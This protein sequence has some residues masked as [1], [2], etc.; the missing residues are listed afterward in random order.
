[1]SWAYGAVGLKA[2]HPMRQ[3]FLGKTGT[4]IC[5]EDNSTSLRK[6][7][8]PLYKSHR[9]ER[10]LRRPRPSH[11][12]VRVFQ[13]I[14]RE[15]ASLNLVEFPGLEA[16]DLIALLAPK[17]QLPIIA[18]DKDLLQIPGVQINKLDGMPLEIAN[19]A[20]RLPKYVQP[21]VKTPEDI[22]LT[23][24]LMG[25]KSD[26]IPRLVRPRELAVMVHLLGTKNRWEI[27]YDMFKGDL[28]RNLYLAVLPAPWCF[29]P[30]PTPMQVF[31]S[32]LCGRPIG[33]VLRQD[34]K[35]WLRAQR[36]VLP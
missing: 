10:K 1:M 17:Y 30:V 15:D 8:Y 18:T 35:Q 34:L 24:T 36:H 19:F 9:V 2:W 20:R 25:D 4:L 13:D 14:M 7:F 3:H 11:E 22:L 32:I 21:W 27:A 16:D 6:Q 12:K 5:F 29:N 23:L 26:D 33:R 31:E 28:L